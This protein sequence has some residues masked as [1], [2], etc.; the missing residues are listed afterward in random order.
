MA[1]LA[2][3][4]NLEAQMNKESGKCLPFPAMFSVICAWSSLAMFAGAINTSQTEHLHVP[5]AEPSQ[6]WHVVPMQATVLAEGDTQAVGRN[7]RVI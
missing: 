7:S 5:S 2:A 1:N 6:R 3:L 4:R